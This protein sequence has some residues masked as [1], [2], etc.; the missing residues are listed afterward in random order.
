M[1]SLEKVSGNKFRE[2]SDDEGTA[3]RDYSAQR[4]VKFLNIAKIDLPGNI[5]WNELLKSSEGISDYILSLNLEDYSK[6]IIGINSLIRKKNNDDVWEMDGKGV[7]MGDRDIFPDFEDKEALIGMALDAAREMRKQGR[8]VEDISLLLSVSLTAIHLFLNGNGRTAKFLLTI[9][10]CGYDSEIMK[11]VL[12][13]DSFSN[14]VNAFAFQSAAY[15]VLDPEGKLVNEEFDKFQEKREVRKK[16][17]EIII[18]IFKNDKNSKYIFNGETVLES[19]KKGLKED[20]TKF[21]LY[22]KVFNF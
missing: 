6:L 21:D 4:L 5:S 15:N 16:V 9:M 20:G 13:S 10:N 7:L 17:V 1:T 14:A 8:S 3:L 19:F 18:D 12:M 22:N 11:K 2:E